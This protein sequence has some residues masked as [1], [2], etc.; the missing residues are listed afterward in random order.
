MSLVFLEGCVFCSP[1]AS[2]DTFGKDEG[3]YWQYW[4]PGPKIGGGA[5]GRKAQET[6]SE[7]VRGIRVPITCTIVQPWGHHTTLDPFETAIMAGQ[8]LM[9][10]I[11]MYKRPDT[12]DK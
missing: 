3:H 1:A 10:I 2:V 5:H 11:A 12:L 6:R 4:T 9:R 7:D 8:S